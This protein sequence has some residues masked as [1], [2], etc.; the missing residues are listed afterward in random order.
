MTT[1]V[2]AANSGVN[3]VFWDDPTIW[4]TGSVP[5]SP[6]ADVIFGPLAIGPGQFYVSDITIKTFENFGAGSVDLA[7]N[8]LTIGGTLGGITGGT[9]TVAGLLEIDVAGTL[10]LALGSVSAGSLLNMGTGIQG[11]GQIGVSGTLTNDSQI[12]G[13][14]LTI[15]AG[16]LINTGSLAA[17]FGDLTIVVPSGGFADLSG[18]TLIG[19]S[20][21][22]GTDASNG[23]TITLDIG[24]SIVTD[25]ASISLDGGGTIET[26]DAGS[27]SYVSIQ[28]SLQT[29]ALSGSLAL[30]NATYVWGALTIDGTL[31]LDQATLNA[32]ALNVNFSGR[33]VGSGTIVGA[34]TMNGGTIEARAPAGAQSGTYVLDLAGGEKGGGTLEIGAGSLT[35][36]TFGAA[37]LI[38]TLELGALT[39]ANVAFANNVGI[40]QL[41]DPLE[42]SGTVA[43]VGFGD[44]IALPGVSLSS[45]TGETSGPGPDSLWLQTGNTGFGLEIVGDYT[46]ANFALSAGPANSLVITIVGD[47]STIVP[48]DYQQELLRVGDQGGVSY[49]ASQIDSGVMTTAQV[50][51]MIATSTEAQNDVLPIVR[52]YEGLFGRV[53]DPAGF[54]FWVHLV[55]G[56]E[57]LPQIAG[58]FVASAE[59]ATDY[60]SLSASEFVTAL[61]ENV[62]HRAPDPSGFS[63]WV[64]ALSEMNTATETTVVLGL[65]QST[66]FMN[67]ADAAIEQ[68]LANA[69]ITGVAA[70]SIPVWPGAL[71]DLTGLDS[72]VQNPADASGYA[73]VALTGQDVT[74]GGEFS[75]NLPSAAS[76][77]IQNAS[78]VGLTLAHAGASGDSLTVNFISAGEMIGADASSAPDS[79][80]FVLGAGPSALGFLVST[81]DT[82]VNMIGSLSGFDPQASELGQLAETDNSLTTVTLSGTG[83]FLG[84]GDRNYEGD[85][86]VTDIDATATSP[87][88][89]HSSLT[90]IDA[91]ATTS[92]VEIFVGATN[93]G[94]TVFANGTIL[95]PNVTITYDGLTV[96]GGSGSNYIENDANQG[97]ITD[98][99]GVTDEVILGGA[100]ASAT[101]GTGTGDM[102]SVGISELTTQEAPGAAIGDTV[103]FGAGGTAH[104]IIGTGAETG[105]TAN[106]ANFGQSSVAGASAGMTIDLSAVT[107]SATVEAFSAT[108]AT[109]NG[110]ENAA[111]ASL[112]GAGFAYFTFGGEEY[113]V[114]AHGSETAVAANDAVV[115]LIGVSGLAMTDHAGVLTLT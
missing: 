14:D 9:L 95:N 109:L 30:A 6:Q 1:Y 45:I 11:G 92:G 49:W 33:V 77:L 16:A 62:L 31:S 111:V 113:I 34:V 7:G 57:S 4:S 15:T 18:T 32:A 50:A 42:F 90:L 79:D 103:T 63:Y 19:G 78:A 71:L 74:S 106:T 85:G 60:G 107:T 83:L 29:V 93:T 5:N 41:D 67:D 48:Q 37:P 51:Q 114:A 58:Q 75:F 80:V 25:A 96:E 24:S 53:P 17:S 47:G 91:S 28:S 64:S 38:D 56:G 98:G 84:T 54:Q 66:E 23:D 102:A 87:V 20:Y 35:G 86:V 3:S 69:G 104:L 82:Q 44:Q 40:L 94:G 105:V 89:V 88:T 101:L 100:G 2:F 108:Q 10:N 81:G 8:V 39:Q 13:S 46:T 65:T 76:V 115:H 27:S 61:Y 72:T 110:A 68:W 36:G 52:L 112:A 26:Y 99:N 59:F 21:A 73:G 97:V 43:P 70:D 55:D 12:V 22:A